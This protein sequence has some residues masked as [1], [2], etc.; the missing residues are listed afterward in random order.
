MGFISGWR[1]LRTWSLTLV[2]TCSSK[3]YI[4]LF[5]YRL[6]RK[7]LN[8]PLSD[9]VTGDSP[10]LVSIIYSTTCSPSSPG[11]PELALLSAAQHKRSLEPTTYFIFSPAGDKS[12]LTPSSL[13]QL[14][15]STYSLAQQGS[16]VPSLETTMPCSK[17]L[18]ENIPR[19]SLES[20][21]HWETRPPP[22]KVQSCSTFM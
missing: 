13:P 20:W 1:Q 7:N 16:C 4:P 15:K 22:R 11:F 12:C 9:E 19:G 21:D 14:Q 18:P 2:P 3:Y 5:P 8:L 10:A 6:K 17:E